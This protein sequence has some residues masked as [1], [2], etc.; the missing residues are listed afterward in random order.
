[1]KSKK[2]KIC[3]D[4]VYV[5]KLG[6]AEGIYENSFCSNWFP[7]SLVINKWFPLRSILFTIEGDYGCDLLYHSP[8]YPVFNYSSDDLLLSMDDDIIIQN[9][10]N[11]NSILEFFGYDNYLNIDD[12][13]RIRKTFFTGRFAKDNC[14]LFGYR[15]VKADK[16]RFFLDGKEVKDEIALHEEREKFNLKHGL[17][18]RIFVEAE[19]GPFS[20][21]L[22]KLIDSFGDERSMDL[23]VSFV[24]KKDA[25]M[26]HYSE[27]PIKKLKRF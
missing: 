18:N 23:G 19:E 26:P 4:N 15:E 11:L 22:F 25:F 7:Q 5:G 12:L 10:C 1:M 21:E 20:R 8:N 17:G 9:A 2:Y 13:I 16:M 27:G 14:T 3:R 6:K 24:L